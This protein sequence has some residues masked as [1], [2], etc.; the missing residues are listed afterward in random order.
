MSAITV[1]S[2]RIVALSAFGLLA[3]ANRSDAQ[4]GEFPD[5]SPSDAEIRKRLEP[6]VPTFRAALL[7][8]NV[9]SQRATL[10]VIADI[11]PGLASRTNLNASLAAFLQRDHKDPEVLALAIRSFGRSVPV[12]GD[13]EMSKAVAAEMGK[14][15]GK[16][17]RSEH[18][19]VRQAVAEG[20]G[21]A[22]VNA[23]PSVWLAPR[24]EHFVALSLQTIPLLG[25]GIEDKSCLL[26]TSDAADE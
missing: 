10:A 4:V 12:F 17:V 19:I 5:E 9:E 18:A 21:S 1:A 24:A 15:F 25:T 8:D 2:R 6:L 22:I 20:I 23:T 16:H 11:P 14:L 26:Y 3:I 13:A 7:G